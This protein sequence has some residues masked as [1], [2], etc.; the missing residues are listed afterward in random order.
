MRP[1]NASDRA[2]GTIHRSRRNPDMHQRPI[3]A[4]PQNFFVANSLAIPRTAVHFEGFPL[5]LGGHDLNSRADRFRSAISV[6]LLCCGIPE[7]DPAFEIGT[8]DAYRR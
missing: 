8:N 6:E 4:L 1:G 3:L 5:P 7:D 2:F